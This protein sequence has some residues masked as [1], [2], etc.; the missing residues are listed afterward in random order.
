MSVT[1]TPLNARYVADVGDSAEPETATRPVDHRAEHI[2]GLTS[3]RFFAALAVVF[4]H[5]LA[6]WPLPGFE[7][8]WRFSRM[9]SAGVSL[10]FTLSGF[11]LFYIYQRAFETGQLN[12]REFLLSRFARIY[13]VYL[14]G[15]VLAVPGFIA[16]AAQN[17]NPAAE[18]QAVMTVPLLLQAWDPATA[19]RWNC[20]GWSLSAEAFFYVL[21]P[22]IGCLA[23][24]LDRRTVWLSFIALYALIVA[25]PLG[26]LI[27]DLP[28]GSS[29][30]NAMPD[31]M[32]LRFN[33]LVRLPEFILGILVARVGLASPRR[34]PRWGV[35]VAAAA[36]IGALY[37]SYYLPQNV[38][39]TLVQNGVYAPL[40]ALLILAIA[41]SPPTV[42]DGPLWVRLGAA[43]YALY[44]I[45]MPIW[46]MFRFSAR[47]GF[48]ADPTQDLPFYV[49][50]LAVIV[51]GSLAVHRYVEAPCRDMI[52]RWSR[53]RQG[54]AR[55]RTAAE[56]SMQPYPSVHSLSAIRVM[57]AETQEKT[58]PNH[59]R[60]AGAARPA[61]AVTAAE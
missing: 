45:H 41:K 23:A 24:R 3:L 44:I 48:F 1:L 56:I 43:S 30:I 11:I 28:T 18:L 47:N 10:F 7:T 27:A 53:A 13:P 14:V 42:L 19:C 5:T 21:F 57:R 20:P 25:A 60:T 38:S 61:P 59:A 49:C 40:F 8:L 35:A 34:I 55:T 4:Y 22:V 16:G 58:F 51:G 39:E 9:G 15:L 36:V 6:L 33:P 50:Y 17:G 12:A 2:A 31:L 46:G 37:G 26:Y 32:V 29:D 54:R 52:K